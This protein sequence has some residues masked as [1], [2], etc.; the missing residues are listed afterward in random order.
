MPSI[1][2]VSWAAGVIGEE[3]GERRG[4]TLNK[5]NYTYAGWKPDDHGH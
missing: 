5:H 1:H 2:A 3:G 4:V